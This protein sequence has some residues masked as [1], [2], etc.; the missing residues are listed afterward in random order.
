V[1]AFISLWSLS[2]LEDF[3]SLGGMGNSPRSRIAI[4]PGLLRI[5]DG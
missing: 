2:A 1:S 3:A 4:D 5:V